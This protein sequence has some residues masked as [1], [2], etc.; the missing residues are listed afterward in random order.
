MSKFTQSDA[1]HTGDMLTEYYTS[2]RTRE[3]ALARVLN[4]NNDTVAGYKKRGSIQSAIL[5]EISNALKHNF[6]ADLAAQL[7]ATYT[8]N[9]P[10]PAAE[11]NARIA[12]LEQ[13]L[14]IVKAERDVIAKIL[15]S[16]S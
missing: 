5:W 1:P 8:T 4:R 14:A 11:A 2:H 9:A 10:D 13:E 16:R 6:F 15:S 3:F 12:E 7:P